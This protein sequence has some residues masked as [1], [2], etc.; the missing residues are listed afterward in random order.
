M[1]RAKKSGQGSCRL[2]PFRLMVVLGFAVLLGGA[3]AVPFQYQTETLWYKTGVDKVLLRTGQQA[4]LT[5]LVL[6]LAQIVLSLRGRFLEG[7]FGAACLL[8]WHRFNGPLLAC[9][10]CCHAILVL[11]PEGLGNIPMG[12]KY[13][14]EMV[15]EGLFIL[16]LATVLLSQFRSRLQLDYKTWRAVH[17]PLGYLI[18]VLALIH[19]L[20]VSESFAQGAPR[21]VLLV[22]FAVLTLFA[23]LVKTGRWR[24]RS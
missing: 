12:K 6:L 15:G 21:A 24:A 23:V 2:V 3:L 20:F 7:L 16:L 11:A 9:T 1:D 19:V 14:P 13:W 8:R 17:R 18:P 22:V 4:G 10:A 5:T